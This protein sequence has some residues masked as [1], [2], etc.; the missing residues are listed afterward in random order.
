MMK[1]FA[2]RDLKAEAFGDPLAIATVGLATRALEE[3]LKAPGS[4][5]AKNPEDYILYQIGE[6][7]P[8]FGK[9]VPFD[10]PRPV[11]TLVELL[12]ALRERQR[13]AATEDQKVREE[14]AA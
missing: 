9:V 2:V 12:S 1:L 13:V 10:S 7:D 11:I 5:F 6:Y 4:Q 3:A 14:V 8:A